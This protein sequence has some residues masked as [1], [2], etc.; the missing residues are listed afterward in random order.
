MA[1]AAADAHIR[2]TERAY[3]RRR[4]RRSCSRRRGSERGDPAICLRAVRYL[5]MR[6]PLS[7]YA[8]SATCLR[9][10]VYHIRYLPTRCPLS[11]YAMRCTPLLPLSAYAK[12]GTDV[13]GLNGTATTRAEKEKAVQGR[14]AYFAK[15]VEAQSMR[16]EHRVDGLRVEGGGQLQCGDDRGY[17]EEG[18]GRREEGKGMM[19][20]RC[21]GVKVKVEGERS[22]VKVRG[23]RSVWFEVLLDPVTLGEESTR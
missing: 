11:V 4:R 23:G 8:L 12:R 20:T 18:S 13:S 2:G 19:G 5:S 21:R 22:R 1:Y 17:R 6:C 3:C 9:V 16:A 7:A 15:R 14:L 10:T